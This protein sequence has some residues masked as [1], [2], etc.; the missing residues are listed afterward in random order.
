MVTHQYN[1]DQVYELAQ[2]K[3]N[4]HLFE[5]MKAS[6]TR[7]QRELEHESELKKLRV[8]LAKSR[9]LAR[10]RAETE[11]LLKNELQRL[12][13]ELAMR[14]EPEEATKGPGEA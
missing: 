1:K 4:E 9:K 11:G 8:E 12:K 13:D 3:D 10:R 7:H 14:V 5:V 6:Q 2:R